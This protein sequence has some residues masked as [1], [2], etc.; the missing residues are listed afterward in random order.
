[1]TDEDTVWY[2]T[3]KRLNSAGIRVIGGEPPGGA[4]ALPRIE[5]KHPDKTAKGSW[6][7]RKCDLY[8]VHDST[9]LLIEAKDSHSKVQGDVDKMVDIIDDP[10]WAGALWDAMDERRLAARNGFPDRAAFVRDRSQL[11]APVLA[12][13]PEPGFEPPE[14]FLLI[15][16][17]E[18]ATTARVR[19]GGASGHLLS[20]VTEFLG[21]S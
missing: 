20:A 12:V 1:M 15:E 5:M 17:D 8:A 9:L 16:T 21:G 19:G 18:E 13:P 14:G 10:D 2:Y 7:S 6:G 3:W 11:I 4:A